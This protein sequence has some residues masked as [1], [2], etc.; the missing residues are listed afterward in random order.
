MSCSCVEESPLLV[1]LVR[2]QNEQTGW[3]PAKLLWSSGNN[4]DL[5]NSIS[6]LVQPRSIVCVDIRK[7]ACGYW[8]GVPNKVAGE[9]MIAIINVLSMFSNRL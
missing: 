3:S 9:C 1:S 6:E 5:Q 7:L 8:R 4:Q 2:G